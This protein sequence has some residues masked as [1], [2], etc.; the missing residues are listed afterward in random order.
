MNIYCIGYNNSNVFVCDL[1][2]N[3]MFEI[4]AGCSKNFTEDLYSSM[5]SF[6]DGNITL[7]EFLDDIEQE[8]GFRPTLIIPSKTLDEDSLLMNDDIREQIFNSMIKVGNVNTGYT[9]I[10][11]T[12]SEYVL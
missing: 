5:N 9:F 10:P 7:E 8:F 11:I 4:E 1:V 3:N 2:L 12:M 6:L